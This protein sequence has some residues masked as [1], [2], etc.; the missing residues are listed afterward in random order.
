MPQKIRLRLQFGVVF[1]GILLFTANANAQMTLM[2]QTYTLAAGQSLR[3]NVAGAGSSG[4]QWSFAPSLGTLSPNGSTAV[5]QAPTRATAG[6]TISVTATIMSSPSTVLT[7]I[8]TLIPAVVVAIT[9]STLQMDA[10]TQQTFT[11]QVQGSPN[12]ALAWSATGGQVT[13]AGVFTA[14]NVD[15]PAQATVSAKPGADHSQSATATVSIRPKPTIKFTTQANG[16]QTVMFN[17]VNYNYI[18]GENM[19]TMVSVNTPNG[20]ARINPICNG[21]F[22][23]TVVTQNCQT[24]NGDTLTAVVTFSSPA[25]PAGVNTAP[26]TNTGTLEADIQVTNNS[27]TNTIA[28]VMLSVLGVQMPKFNVGASSANALSPYNV[29]SSVNFGTGQWAIW[30]NSPTAD[31]GTNMA[32]GWVNVCKNQPLIDNIAPGQTKTASFSLRF[33]NDATATMINLAPEAFTA[34]R[35]VYPPVVNWPDRRP[36]MAWWLADHGH[37]SA[38]NP[39]GYLWNASL[40]VSNAQT[41]AASMLGQAQGILTQMKSRAVQ[42]QGIVLWNLEGEEFIQPTTYIGDPR[43]LDPSVGYAPEMNAVADQ[44]FAMFTNAGYKVGVTLRPQYMQWGTGPLP[45]TCNYSADR[46]DTDFYIQIGATPPWNGSFYECIGPNT[47]SV[48]IVGGNGFQTTYQPTQMAQEIALLTAKAQY[49]HN[50]WGAT[51]FYVD[52]AVWEGGGPLPQDIFRA[53]EQAMPDCLFM[54]EQSYQATVGTAIP[55][56]D[57]KNAPN[58][59]PFAPVS[60]RWIYPTGAIASYLSNCVGD[61]NCWNNLSPSYSIGQRIG[62]IPLYAVPTQMSPTQYNN[63]EAMITQARTLAGSITV[64]DTSSGAHFTY[65][66]NPATA[67][68]TAQPPVPYPL[69]M[70]VYFAANAAALPASTTYCENGQWQGQNT[71]NLNLNGLVTAQIRYYDFTDTLVVAGPAQGR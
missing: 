50:R 71:C 22:T 3:F 49:A 43:V 5:Y 1:T 70:R 56:S 11:A 63:V 7:A 36:I 57:A 12:Q 46:N 66:G 54:P 16:L 2:P 30:N 19:V 31:T 20:T 44:V 51:L 4:V 34:F 58:D 6:Q 41:F 55:F 32:C 48:P 10:G 47:W 60:W 45:A 40:D 24:N 59:P 68:L 28:Q 9:P 15:T 27:A 17:N 69:K 37:L 39:R 61:G 42:P 18:Y 35:T 64:T 26:G 33:T 21:T 25:P 67:G 38:T 62:D 23:P 8:V 13:A 14:P 65:T 29:I 53:L 52:S